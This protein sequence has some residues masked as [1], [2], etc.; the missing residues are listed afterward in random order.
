MGSSGS[1]DLDQFFRSPFDNDFNVDLDSDE[2]QEAVQGAA[3]NNDLELGM[4]VIKFRDELRKWAQECLIP[5]S[6]I[7][8][9]LKILKKDAKIEALSVTARTL[10]GTANAFLIESISGVDLHQFDVKNQICRVIER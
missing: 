9:L 1:M 8:K 3:E 2:E 10:L 4:D 7:D 5:H 6:H